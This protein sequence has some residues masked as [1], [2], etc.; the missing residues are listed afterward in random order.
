MARDPQERAKSSDREA[1]LDLIERAHAE[2]RLGSADRTIRKN[3]VATA[4]TLAELEMITR[5]L[6]ADVAAAAAAAYAP[7]VAEP[8]P[9]ADEP[10][11]LADQWR[12][13]EAT[14]PQPTAEPAAGAPEPVMSVGTAA[15]SGQA[16]PTQPTQPSEWQ[17]P[18]QAWMSRSI[19]V[20]RTLGCAP[21]LIGLV[22]ALVGISIAVSVF[23]TNVGLPEIDLGGLDPEPSQTAVVDE[24]A[25]TDEGFGW[26]IE[27][28]R[29]SFG[30][31]TSWETVFYPGDTGQG[32]VI[33]YAPN[34]DGS[35]TREGWIYRAGG[36][37]EF[38]STPQAN[39]ADDEPINLR[40]VDLAALVD[41]MNTAITTLNV[42]DAKVSHIIV[43]DDAFVGKPAVTIYVTNGIGQGAFMQTD[44][45]GNVIRSF[46]NAG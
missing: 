19:Q 12:T 5:D 33:F 7:P 27:R 4:S 18:A 14:S 36:F 46:P 25:M 8:Q 23:L 44:L 34:D 35:D 1:A 24:Y 39:P 43:K 28:Y 45:R 32:Y 21:A 16:P 22:A 3:N 13:P 40:R 15:G 37:T 41:N 9:V 17:I 11:T 20:K 31:T 29:E 30:T 10:M 6:V 2:G 42:D 26:V 38:G